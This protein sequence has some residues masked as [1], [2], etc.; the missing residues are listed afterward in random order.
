MIMNDM[1][2]E[3]EA[4]SSVFRA[5]RDD[6][7]ER[8]RD[9]NAR[10]R[11]ADDE[12]RQLMVTAADLGL[13]IRQIA[14][15]TGDGHSSVALWIKRARTERSPGGDGGVAAAESAASFR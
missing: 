2:R 3:P 14:A 5:T 1:P 4:I 11:R 13:T 10:Y 9:A 8:L 12:R 15:I 6:V 7:V